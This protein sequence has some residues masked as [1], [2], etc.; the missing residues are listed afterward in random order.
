M[1]AEQ[2]WYR[3]QV[4]VRSIMLNADIQTVTKVAKK[5]YAQMEFLIDSQASEAGV[6]SE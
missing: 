4:F 5:V 2:L 1:T 6:K 3:T